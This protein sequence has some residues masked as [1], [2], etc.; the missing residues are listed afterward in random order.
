MTYEVTKEE[1]IQLQA[2]MDRGW[3]YHEIH[4]KS[5]EGEE[6]IWFQPGNLSETFAVKLSRMEVAKLVTDN[7]GKYKRVTVLKTVTRRP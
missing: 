4:L 6:V 7:A 2:W 3:G 5:P 1:R